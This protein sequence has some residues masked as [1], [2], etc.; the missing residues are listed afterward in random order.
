MLLAGSRAA[1]QC[2]FEVIVRWMPA[3]SY[4]MQLKLPPVLSTSGAPAGVCGCAGQADRG[5]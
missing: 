4:Q 2:P 5:V 3:S 1:M